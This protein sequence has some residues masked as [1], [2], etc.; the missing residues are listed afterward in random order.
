M[1]S[2]ITIPKIDKLTP[3]LEKIRDNNV[4]LKYTCKGIKFMSLNKNNIIQLDELNKTKIFNTFNTFSTAMY[5]TLLE[6]LPTKIYLDF[7]FKNIE[8]CIY[9]NKKC[10]LFDIDKYLKNF[11]KNND[12]PYTNVIYTDASRLIIKNNIKCYKISFH[13]V[14]NGVG[15][16]N[17][18][19]LKNLILEFIKSIDDDFIKN[20]VDDSVYK[21]PQL[22]KCILSRANDG[23]TKLIEIIPTNSFQDYKSFNENN[24]LEYLSGIYNNNYICLDEKFNHLDVVITKK[25]ENKKIDENLEIGGNLE[26]IPQKTISWIYSNPLISGIYRMKNNNVINN[27]INLLRMKSSYC[28]ICKRIHENENAYILHKNNNLYFHCGRST[29][30]GK[31]IGKLKIISNK[32]NED[33]LNET[34]QKLKKYIIELEEKINVIS[35]NYSGIV[36]K[37]EKSNK[38]NIKIYSKKPNEGMWGKYYELGKYID[39]GMENIYMNIAC[40]WNDRNFSRLKNRALRIYNYLNKYSNNEKN[41]SIK[42]IFEFKN[43]EYNIIMT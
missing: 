37:S 43:K 7:D 31:Y 21:V 17:R 32:S 16:K 1:I 22:F 33:I 18:N 6:G 12:I 42:Q 5:E 8:Y 24:I 38:N 2:N 25:V 10:I 39:A 29:S 40:H 9:N 35:K 23:G 28:K 15:F 20:A 3:E 41:L 27:K 30:I 14:V 26:N 36:K 4:L 19:I 11:L 13:V 34:I